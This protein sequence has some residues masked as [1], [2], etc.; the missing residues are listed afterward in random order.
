MDSVN[1]SNGTDWSFLYY[2]KLTHK[3]IIK[4]F[5]IKMNATLLENF[6]KKL[7]Q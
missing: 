6:I 1:C 5:I 2:T 7:N 3:A 4:I